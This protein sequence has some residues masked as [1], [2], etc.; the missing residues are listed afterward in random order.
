MTFNAWFQALP[1][2]LKLLVVLGI[3]LGAFGLGTSFVVSGYRVW[4]LILNALSRRGRDK[5]GPKY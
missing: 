4:R 1:V 3:V 5:G 2:F